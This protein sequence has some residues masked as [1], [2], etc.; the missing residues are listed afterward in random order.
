MFEK[1]QILNLP[2]APFDIQQLPIAAV[3]TSDSLIA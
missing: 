1:L 3:D 2:K